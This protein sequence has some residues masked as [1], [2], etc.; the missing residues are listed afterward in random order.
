MGIKI[1]KLLSNKRF[2]AAALAVLVGVGGGY[3]KFKPRK[4][5]GMRSSSDFAKVEKGN[6]E[7]RFHEIGELAALHAVDVVSKVNGRI[8]DVYVQEGQKVK[9]GDKL[10]L[11]QPGKSEEERYVPVT[12]ASPMEGVVMPPPKSGTDSGLGQIPTPGTYVNGT[13]DNT[14]AAPIMTI[15]DMRQMAVE[16]QIS[17]VD[18][19]KLQEGLPVEVSLSAI[20]GEKFSGSIN[21]VS[22][23]AFKSSGNLRVFRVQ[24]KVDKSDPRLRYGM[25]AQVEAILQKKEAVLKAPHAAVFEEEGKNVVYVRNGKKPRRT[26]VVI[27]IKNETEIEIQSGLKEGDELYLEKPREDEKK[28]KG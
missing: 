7:V 24:A 2:L 3:W 26:E 25:T 6:L 5:G 1:K 20:A 23:R 16:L 22:P 4:R 18:I 19:L 15:A 21:L 12:L 14:S 8:L 27:G 11:I 13:L 28:Q 17:E 9:R 10:A